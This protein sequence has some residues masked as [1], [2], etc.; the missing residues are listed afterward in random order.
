[1]KASALLFLGVLAGSSDSSN[2]AL[3]DWGAELRVDVEGLVRKGH[4]RVAVVREAGA[5]NGAGDALVEM[6]GEVLAEK[7]RFVF[8]LPPG[9]LAVRLFQDTNENGK[10]DSNALGVPVEPYGFSGRSAS[11]GAPSFRE[12][13][14]DLPADGTSITIS[15]VRP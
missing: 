15:V 9:K 13:A 7:M 10:L 3:P 11:R 4:I 12:A 8:V 6:G 14:V 5:W 2:E 1:M